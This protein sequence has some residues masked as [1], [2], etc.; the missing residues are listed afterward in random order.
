VTA[1]RDVLATVPRRPGGIGTVAAS[2]HPVASGLP[3][4][5]AVVFGVLSVAVVADLAGTTRSYASTSTGAARLDLTAG[6]CLVATGGFLWWTHQR[7]A[8][9]VLSALVGAT[10]PSADWI[11]G[12]TAR[13]TRSCCEPNPPCPIAHRPL[14]ARSVGHRRDDRRRVRCTPRAGV[15]RPSSTCSRSSGIPRSVGHLRVARIARA[16]A[17][18]GCARPQG[19]ECPIMLG[20]ETSR[21]PGCGARNACEVSSVG[22]PGIDGWASKR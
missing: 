8:I 19:V 1:E 14:A 22:D 13:T 17:L 20:I 12:A 16:T 10:W 15:P 7:A 6:L 11:A 5:L 9:G 4:V 18:R 3:I 2:R 21:A